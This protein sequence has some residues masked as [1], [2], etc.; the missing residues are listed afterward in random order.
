MAGPLSADPR[1]ADDPLPVLDLGAVAEVEHGAPTRGDDL[2]DD[3]LPG[4]LVHLADDDARALGGELQRLT[5]TE[6]APCAGD[7]RDLAVQE[8]H[9]AGP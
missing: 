6:A 1:R 2:V 4:R 8:S 5:A 9:A 3:R 7:D